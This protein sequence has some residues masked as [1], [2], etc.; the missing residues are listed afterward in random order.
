M[1][2]DIYILDSSDA[3]LKANCGLTWLKR[4]QRGACDIF[5]VPHTEGP[6]PHHKFIVKVQIQAS[7]RTERPNSPPP[8]SVLDL[9]RK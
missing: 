9:H 1:F 2:E 6:P 4:T 3:I 8:P 5:F 7:P